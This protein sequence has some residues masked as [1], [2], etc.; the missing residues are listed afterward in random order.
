MKFGIIKLQVEKTTYDY[1]SKFIILY[2]IL[3]NLSIFIKV[4]NTSFYLFLLLYFL[5]AQ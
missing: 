2:H 3:H 1:F 5:Y 4:K